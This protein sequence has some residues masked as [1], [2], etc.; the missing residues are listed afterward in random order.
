MAWDATVTLVQAHN[1]EDQ[2]C[3]FYTVAAGMDGCFLVSSV[4]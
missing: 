1:S 2:G 4:L 3:L